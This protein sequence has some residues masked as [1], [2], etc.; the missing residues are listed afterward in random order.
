MKLL[1]AINAI[2]P[3]LGEAP[4]TTV[5][6]RH[7]TVAL[8]NSAI[9]IARQELLAEGWWFNEERRTLYVDP[10]GYI[11]TPANLLALYSLTSTQLEPRGEYL[12]DLGTG[13][14]LFKVGGTYDCRL[15][16]DL[17]FE[18]LPHYA[19]LYVQY[20]AGA[21]AYTQDFG[22]EKVVATFQESAQGAYNM[23]E[24]EELRKRK[25]SGTTNS[26]RAELE[27]ALRG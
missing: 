17:P 12:Y 4:V 10:E 5:D 26:I 15:V 11:P 3:M 22:V 1:D 24:Q 21:T 19:A 7:P 6:A 2:L 18:H 8:I 25:Y 23:L 13:S 27:S 9:N 16:V 14:I 20:V